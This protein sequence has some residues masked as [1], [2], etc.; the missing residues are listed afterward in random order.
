MLNTL[1][2]NNIQ[3]DTVYMHKYTCDSAN[4]ITTPKLPLVFGKAGYLKVGHRNTQ[5]T[6]FSRSTPSYNNI[7]VQ[8]K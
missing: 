1:N 6:H 4:Y 2:E 5:L 7:Q 3:L 8:P